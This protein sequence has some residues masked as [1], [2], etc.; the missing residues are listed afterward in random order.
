MSNKESD[1]QIIK[2]RKKEDLF[3]EKQAE[4][5]QAAGVTNIINSHGTDDI[6]DIDRLW[7]RV[8]SK[9]VDE[10]LIK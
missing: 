4:E 1:L 9:M 6:D 2:R 5:L 7:W 3:V 8:L 10:Y